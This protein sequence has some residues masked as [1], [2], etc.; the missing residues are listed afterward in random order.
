MKKGVLIIYFILFIQGAYAQCNSLFFSSLPQKEFKKFENFKFKGVN[1]CNTS[2]S[3]LFSIE[4]LDSIG[5]WQ[6]FD[7]DIFSESPWAQKIIKIGSKKAKQ[8]VFK[9][10]EIDPKVISGSVKFRI[11]V[12]V[13]SKDLIQIAETKNVCVFTVVR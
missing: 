1:K 5:V 13:F 6:E 2:V 8:F 11:V 9:I 7:N 12:N 3:V 10:N 4:R